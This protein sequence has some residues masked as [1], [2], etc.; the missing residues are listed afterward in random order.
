MAELLRLRVGAGPVANNGSD[1]FTVL[2]V[3][4]SEGDVL[5]AGGIGSTTLFTATDPE[6]SLY[7]RF[8]GSARMRVEPPVP[9]W[10]LLAGHTLASCALTLAA[11][12]TG[13]PVEFVTS[14]SVHNDGRVQ[15]PVGLS[16]EIIIDGPLS[17]DVVEPVNFS[18]AV[19]LSGGAFEPY[20][21]AVPIVGELVL[22]EWVLV[23]GQLDLPA[24]VTPP[25]AV[26]IRAGKG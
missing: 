6:W 19:S 14:V 23:V 4:E 7:V 26:A 9:S 16:E 22:E 5:T 8:S 11:T 13:D 10:K 24:W 18:C 21:G 20:P 17:V 15:R 25:N 2:A 3:E 12:G 1:D